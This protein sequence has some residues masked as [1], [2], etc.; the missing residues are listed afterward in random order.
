MAIE[1]Q[2]PF[3]IQQDWCIIII[4]HIHRILMKPLH[5]GDTPVGPSGSYYMGG[6]N[7]GQDLGL[8]VGSQVRTNFENLPRQVTVR[9]RTN[10]PWVR[11]RL[12]G[13]LR[14]EHLPAN[15]FLALLPKDKTIK[16]FYNHVEIGQHA[17]KFFEELT[18]EKEAL[19][20]AVASLNTVRRKGK[21][22]I[23]IT[24]LVE[25]DCVQD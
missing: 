19:A 13:T 3:I 2:K 12:C 9:I 14:F 16:T 6:A 22:N 17:H 10:A 11:D 8:E 23:H 5:N 25:D 4:D 21:A 7:K 1:Q 15:W 20:K 18:F 24:K